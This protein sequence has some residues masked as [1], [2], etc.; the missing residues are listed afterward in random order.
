M[1][2]PA[3]KYALDCDKVESSAERIVLVEYANHADDR[4]YTWPSLKF[5]ASVWHADRESLR[6]AREAIIGRGLLFRTKKRRGPTGQNKVFRMPKC[7]YERG[8]QTA[9][10]SSG[11][12]AAK[13]RRRGGE[14]VAKPPRTLIPDTGTPNH[15]IKALGSSLA[16]EVA[17]IVAKSSESFDGAYQNH[18][19]WPE[20][21]QWCAKKNGT[22][23]AEGFTTW[24]LGQK[25]EWRNKIKAGVEENG[26]ELDGKFYPQ[27][28]ANQ[29]ASS[30]PDLAVRFRPATRRNGQVVVKHG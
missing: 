20:F 7:T 14:A 30:Q 12:E 27:R 17:K 11:E 24:L 16:D 25:P 5:I 26:Y 2:W 9:P 29:L 19:K 10:S 18:I 8:S 15:D 22:P 21:A 23:T 3:L 4:G 1:S 28:E 6:R 13:G